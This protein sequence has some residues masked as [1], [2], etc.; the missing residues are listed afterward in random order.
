M[1]AFTVRIKELDDGPRELRGPITDEWLEAVLRDTEVR[2]VGR[3][4]GRIDVSLTKSGREVLVRGRLAVTVQVPCA[5]TLDPA[6][7]ELR[8]EVFLLLAPG[9]A[10]PDRRE[11]PG[12]EQSRPRHAAGGRERGRRG[13]R[14]AEGGGWES[15]PILSAEV[16]ATDT[17]TGDQV[18]LDEFLREFILLELPMVPLR[19]DLRAAPTEANPPL[20]GGP[21]D[22]AATRVA[23]A[24]DRQIDRQGTE[25]TSGADER[26]LDPRLS[27]LVALKA[28][29]EKKE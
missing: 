29:L 21:G 1:G 26:P 15:D 18:V 4:D 27:P 16:A 14:D 3:G 5:R 25:R 28:R 2:P 12:R 10:S 9:A 20:P 13:G 22:L 19:E 8:P 11:V 23:G 24:V 17:Y 6:I 7:Y